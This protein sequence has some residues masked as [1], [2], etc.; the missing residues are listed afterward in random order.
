MFYIFQQFHC[1]ICPNKIF[2]LKE[3]Y[4][5]HLLLEHSTLPDSVSCKECNVVCPDNEIL[6]LHIKKAHLKEFACEHCGREFA[7]HSHVLRHMAQKGCG[8]SIAN[9]PCEVSY[10]SP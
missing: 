1:K 10:F 4:E 8:K 9:Y 7:R 5:T 6:E 2:K 3:N